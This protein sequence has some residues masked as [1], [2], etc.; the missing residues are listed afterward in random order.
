MV[1]T[2]SR[3]RRTTFGSAAGEFVIP[4]RPRPRGVAICRARSR[5][6]ASVR[7]E[8]YKRPT[9][10]VTL[11]D[12][13]AP[14]RLNRP[15]VLTGEAR[16]YFGLPVSS[17]RVRWRVTREPQYP[18][19]WWWGRLRARTSGRRSSRAGIAPLQR[20]R[21]V[22]GSRSRPR[23]TSASG[24]DARQITYR[25]E[26]AADVTDEGGETRSAERAFRLGFVSVEARVRMD[27][28]FF[29]EGA[30]GS[31]VITRSDLDGVAA[32]GK[33]QL[34][35]DGHRRSRRRRSCP[36]SM[37]PR[38]PP[39]RTAF[40]TPGDR[41]RPRWDT[42][43]ALEA[44]L[45]GW[46]DGAEEARGDARPTTPRARR[47]SRSRALAAGAYRLHYE[48]KDE[49]GATFETHEGFPRRRKA[50]RRSHLPA[51]LLARALLGAASARRARLLAFRACR[52]RASLSRRCA[53]E[54]LTSRRSLSGWRGRR[55]SRCPSARPT[56]AASA[57]R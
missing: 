30:G 21:H 5:A 23:R 13:A 43:V 36:P 47:R 31:V 52:A 26:V 35:A 34:A 18:P 11:E 14:L 7:V 17:G 19:W 50:K 10:E 2:T 25:Y 12:P 49:F 45:R 6:A 39:S 37:P 41:L 20:R 22:R 1:E 38:A 46:P 48:T 55:C 57:S 28:G 29:R 8:E 32:R 56:A 33:G 4:G 44:T 15:A 42:D 27:A 9:F 40:A 16:Y 54:K 3:A 24:R 51:V 53:T